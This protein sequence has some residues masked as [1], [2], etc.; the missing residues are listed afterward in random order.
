[1]GTIPERIRTWEQLLD[2]GVKTIT[3]EIEPGPIEFDKD[4]VVE[5]RVC[6][7][8]W[9]EAIDYRGARFIIDLQDAV[10]RTA[11]E[12]LENEASLSELR[13]KVTVKVKVV[14]G[15]SLFQINIGD[16][17]KAMVTTM[18][19]TQ[20]T[21]MA[22]LA[23]LCAA[24][25]FTTRKI[26]DY[27][28]KVLQDAEHRKLTETAISNLSATMNKALE[29]IR[30]KDIQAPTRKLLNKLDHDDKILLPGEES[31]RPDEA[32]KLYPRKPRIRTESGNFDGQYLIT[33]INMEK[34]PIHFKIIHDEYP[35]WAKA[36]ILDEDIE[37]ISE[38]LK[39]AMKNN[40]DF[41]LNLHMFVVYDERGLKSA[42][43]VST[44]EPRPNA[45]DLSEQIS[46]WKR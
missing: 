16:A 31:M 39:T 4:L 23:I 44:G 24:G 20:L 17:L 18:S 21:L 34:H 13:K 33:A 1:M 35:F 28:Q 25:Y 12:L 37:T 15:S 36:E 30:E 11:G 32:K 3:R 27:K 2:V 43:I 42:S 8:S 45:K 6:G 29:V 5:I 10:S 40:E 46:K 26:L 41:M 9:D 22:G 19:G 7:S 14:K 38:S